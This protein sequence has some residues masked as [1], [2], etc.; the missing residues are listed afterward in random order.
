VCGFFG[1]INIINDFLALTIRFFEH[2]ISWI[3]GVLD[4]QNHSESTN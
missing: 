1:F 3:G 4:D 2:I